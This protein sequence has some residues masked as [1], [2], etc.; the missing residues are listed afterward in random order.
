MIH[1]CRD[2]LTVGNPINL[3]VNRLLQYYM[4]IFLRAVLGYSV[5]GQTNFNIDGSTLRIG[6]G[7]NGSLNQGT[8]NE[9]AFSPDGYVVSAS[10]I[11]RLLAIRSTANPMQN[12][13]IFRVTG[14]D[15]VSNWL[16]VNYRSGDTPPAESD[17]RWVLYATETVF[18]GLINL[19]G[20]GQAGTYTG[21]GSATQ[22]RIVLRSPS[23]IGWELRIAIENSYDC[24]VGA[25]GNVVPG[26]GTTLGAT[27][28]PGFD[29][30]SSGD[31]AAGGRHLHGP[32]FF[33]NRDTALLGTS[34]GWFTGNSNQARVYIWGDDVTGSVFAASRAVL[35]GLDTIVHFGTTDSEE[36]PL[37]S[38]NAQRL[39]V[40]GKNRF[41]FIQSGIQ[42]NS[43]GSAGGA[44]TSNGGMS[45][46]ACNQPV[47]CVYSLYNRLVS[48]AYSGIAARDRTE[49]GDN[50]YLSST[51]LLTVDLLAGT[52]VNFNDGG[53]KAVLQLEGRRIGQAPFVRVGRS[54]Y[55]YFQLTPAGS[56]LWL[57][58]DDGMYLP[59]KGS[60]LP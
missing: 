23:V 57:H 56:E 59:W 15:T 46:G 53:S 45:F 29:G 4:A 20:N 12:S 24:G 30:D 22:N 8:G 6:Y 28:T 48:N 36:L 10:D 33:N 18:N 27:I 47:S 3:S 19:T 21:R 17:M 49:A 60:I 31:F 16:F 1:I 58:T 54:N 55:G 5:V 34:C 25:G 9:Y 14:I 11:G 42:W 52:V 26:D 40:I 44:P 51:E 35:G 38:N 39:F 50:P 41:T 32:M 37:P 7:S 2:L 13:G 43:I